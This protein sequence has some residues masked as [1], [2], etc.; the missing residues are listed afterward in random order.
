MVAVTS[1]KRLT[2]ESRSAT[3]QDNGVWEVTETWQ[4]KFDGEVV[5]P[6][7]FN[8]DPMLPAIGTPHPENSLLYLKGCPNVVP[9]IKSSLRDLNFTLLW[10]TAVLAAADKHDP[11][12]YEDSTRATKSWS[13]RTIQIPVEKA[14]VSDDGGVT[15]SVTKKPIENT[16]ND[17]IIPGITTNKYL[18]TCRYSRN[19]L[20]V[21]TGV[22]DLPG[23]I[24]NDNITLDGKPVGIGQALIIAAPVSSDKRFETYSFR[25]VDYEFLL[26]PEGWD[27]KLLNR[28]FYCK[29]LASGVKERCL[30]KN[31][32]FEGSSDERPYIPSEEPVALDANSIDRRQ[33]EAVPAAFVEHY[34]FFRHLTYT[35][36]SALGFN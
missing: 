6:L 35:S 25:T 16:V 3:L 7:A 28:G 2:N 11:G 26:N 4:A 19:E 14:Y 20:I 32:M 13:H 12:K 1:W 24:N 36:F 17:L 33:R 18:S 5:D 31:G 22:L 10:S 15:F 34:R 9:P 23:L 29:N 30:V 27:E 8:G 21:P